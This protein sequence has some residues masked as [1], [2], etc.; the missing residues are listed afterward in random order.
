MDNQ[1]IMNLSMDQIYNL[2]KESKNEAYE[3]KAINTIQQHHKQSYRNIGIPERFTKCHI[4]SK[5]QYVAGIRL[6]RGTHYF[7][8][9]LADQIAKRRKKFI[10]NKTKKKSEKQIE[11]Q[12]EQEIIIKYALE[13]NT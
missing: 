9:T 8:L 12:K 5:K 11:R 4:H 6:D 13:T 1:Y 7:N 2:Y 10:E 3:L